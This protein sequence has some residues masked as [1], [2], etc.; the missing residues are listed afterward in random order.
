MCLGFPE[1]WQGKR[2]GNYISFVQEGLSPWRFWGGD[3]CPL[4]LLRVAKMTTRQ[5]GA[6]RAERNNP[7]TPSLGQ[8]FLAKFRANSQ[9]PN[10]TFTCHPVL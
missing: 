10:S 5:H 2:T 7:Y 9:H 8:L 3:H 4:L 1:V 6:L